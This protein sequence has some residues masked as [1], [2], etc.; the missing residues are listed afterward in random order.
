MAVDLQPH[1]FAEHPET[2]RSVLVETVPYVQIKQDR[3]ALFLQSGQVSYETGPPLPMEEWPEWL[4]GRILDL[5]E[6]TI[7][8]VGFTEVVQ[9]LNDSG[10]TAA[11]VVARN[12]RPARRF[13]K[14]R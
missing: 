13:G 3:E 14:S 4:P 12:N 6:R 9:A 2:K 11:S 1:K 7:R 5:S 10:A 8:E